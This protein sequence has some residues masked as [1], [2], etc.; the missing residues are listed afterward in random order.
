MISIGTAPCLSFHCRILR[1]SCHLRVRQCSFINQCCHQ[2]LYL[3]LCNVTKLSGVCIENV[4]NS[5]IF[6][7]IP[8]SF[9]ISLTGLEPLAKRV[10]LCR[11]LVFSDCSCCWPEE[12]LAVEVLDAAELV[13]EDVVVVVV[14][15]VVLLA[16][17]V[18]LMFVDE[19]ADVDDDCCCPSLICWLSKDNNQHSHYPIEDRCRVKLQ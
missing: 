8:T 2:S 11:T 5:S 4:L 3:F 18:V 9:I 12:S 10:V 19:L 15:V 14:D 16:V 7:T 6:S 17:V 1:V 13:T